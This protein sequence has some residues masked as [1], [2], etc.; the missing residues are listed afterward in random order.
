MT[1][2]E[3]KEEATGMLIRIC[4]NYKETPENLQLLRELIETHGADMHVIVARRNTLLHEAADRG[5]IEI[6][7]A[8]LER[9]LEVDAKNENDNTPLHFAALHGHTDICRLL[10]EH[11]ADITARNGGNLNTPLHMAMRTNPS[12]DDLNTCRLLIENGADLDATNYEGKSAHNSPTIGLLLKLMEK[13][14]WTPGQPNPHPPTEIQDSAQEISQEER[15]TRFAQTLKATRKKL[16]GY[17]RPD[18]LG[19][20]PTTGGRDGL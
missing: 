1:S 15:E 2:T 3:E 6:C 18:D 13:E 4:S 17:E 5:N 14:G 20:T 12:D 7:R 8:L 19:R 10:I 9:G 16:R 11:G